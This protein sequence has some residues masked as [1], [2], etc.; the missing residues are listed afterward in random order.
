MFI[1]NTMSIEWSSNSG[2]KNKKQQIYTGKK[3]YT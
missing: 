2:S 1:P 3:I